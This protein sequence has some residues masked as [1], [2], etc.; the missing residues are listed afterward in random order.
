M[1]WAMGV[2]H[3][4][5][6][7][8]R[9]GHARRDRPRQEVVRDISASGTPRLSARA[10]RR[11]SCRQHSQVEKAQQL[12]ACRQ[13]CDEVVR[14]S[15]AIHTARWAGRC[16]SLALEGSATYTARGKAVSAQVL[17]PH[18]SGRSESLL[19]DAS[20]SHSWGSSATKAGKRGSRFEDTSKVCSLERSRIESGRSI[21]SLSDT[22]ILSSSCALPIVA[23]SDLSRLCDAYKNCS[24][25]NLPM[26]AGRLKLVMGHAN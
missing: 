2:H 13:S 4:A 23:G 20:I 3:R 21:R 12:H 6:F 10:Y 14:H 11:H 1:R 9:Y 22:S 19:R 8:T 24:A 25:C 26:L 17:L 7:L 18:D 16:G 15:P 5:P